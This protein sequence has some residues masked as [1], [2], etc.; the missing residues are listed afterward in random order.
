VNMRRRYML[1][2]IVWAAVL[3]GLYAMQELFS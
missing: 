3:A 1:V 2:V